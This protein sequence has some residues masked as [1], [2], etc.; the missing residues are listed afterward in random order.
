MANIA[1]TA[2]SPAQLGRVV[3]S[4]NNTLMFASTR[5]RSGKKIFNFFLF[6]YFLFTQY[7]YAD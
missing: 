7:L 5:Q 2:P 6:Y 3:T 4:R 1:S